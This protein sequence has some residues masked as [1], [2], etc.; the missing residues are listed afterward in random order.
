MNYKGNVQRLIQSYESQVAWGDADHE[1]ALHNAINVAFESLPD[2]GK[3]EL[4][5]Q[6]ADAWENY[7][8]GYVPRRLWIGTIVTNFMSARTSDAAA[9]LTVI[10][11]LPKPEA[12]KVEA[13]KAVKK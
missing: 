13:P 9:G 8:D 4:Y 2:E 6:I 11:N 1:D 12:P 3:A 7:R 5:A 10:D